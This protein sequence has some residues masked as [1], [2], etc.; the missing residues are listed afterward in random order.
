MPHTS[1][2]SKIKKLNILSS[3]QEIEFAS[4]ATGQRIAQVLEQEGEKPQYV[5]W[6]IRGDVLLFKKLIDT[7]KAN[8]DFYSNQNSDQGDK[9]IGVCVSRLQAGDTLV[10]EDAVLKK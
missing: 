9:D 8:L 2:V 10:G 7:K 6:I 1:E 4:G 3:F 5:Y